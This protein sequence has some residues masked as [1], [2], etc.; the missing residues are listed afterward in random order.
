MNMGMEQKENTPR[1]ILPF[2]AVQ[3]QHLVVPKARITA[4]CGACKREGDLDPVELGWRFGPLFS[5]RD[6]QK[7]LRCRHCGM[8][9][10]C[11]ISLTWLE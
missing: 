1:K 7:R 4:S 3:I 10:W 9:G 6:L 5:V 11:H 8:K 2:Y